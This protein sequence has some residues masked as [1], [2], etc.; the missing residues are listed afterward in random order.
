MTTTNEAAFSSDQKIEVTF[1][2]QELVAG[3]GCVG[4]EYFVRNPGGEWVRIVDLPDEAMRAAV[5][6]KIAAGECVDIMDLPW[7]D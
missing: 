4:R 3:T 2:W 1:L 7:T 6:A 5:R